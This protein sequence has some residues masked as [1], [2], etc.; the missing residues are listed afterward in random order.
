MFAEADYDTTE[1]AF[2]MQRSAAGGSGPKPGDEH[3]FVK[4]EME[5]VMDTKASEEQGREI[6]KEVPHIEIRAP[7]E[8]SPNFRDVANE[9]HKQRFPQHWEAFTKKNAMPE[10]AGT[11]LD[12]WPGVGVAQVKELNYL[13]IFRVEDL[14]NLSDTVCQ[15]H[16]GL[17]G[18]KEKAKLFLEAAESNKVATQLI[19]A[20]ATIKEMQQQIA[21]MTLQ[22]QSKQA[23][24]A[25]EGVNLEA[26]T[27]RLAEL[28]EAAKP[29]RRGRPKKETADGSEKEAEG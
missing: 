12:K 24:P 9:H 23:A 18:L 26:I 16:M 4:F 25:D 15:K 21:D 5:P 2:Q 1:L 27:A 22:L 28:E 20:Q 19:A 17:S 7:G 11:P 10:A 6:W 3:L 29:K 14:A 8:V 13:S